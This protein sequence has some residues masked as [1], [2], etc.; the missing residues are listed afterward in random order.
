MPKTRPPYPAAFRQQMVDL[1]RSGR[2]PGEL[3][4]EF[5]P[6]AEA[7][8]KWVAQADRDA[9]KRTDGLTTDEQEEIRRL[10]RGNLNL[11]TLHAG[12]GVNRLTGGPGID[13]FVFN[14]TSG[15]AVITDFA[16]D[17]VDLTVFG[18]TRGEFAQQ[19]AIEGARS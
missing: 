16:G 13:L 14:E 10:R 9:G 17:R 2:K 4:R 8:R 19:V 12:P 18:F 5:E 1:V 3:A 6:S 7:I 15:D 11:N